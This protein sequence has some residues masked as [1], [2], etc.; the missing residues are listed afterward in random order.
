MTQTVVISPNYATQDDVVYQTLIGLPLDHRK[1]SQG[2]AQVGDTLVYTADGWRPGQPIHTQT[3]PLGA[4]T[5]RVP[6]LA[7]VMAYVAEAIANSGGQPVQFTVLM[8]ESGEVL[9][10]ESG[11]V[12][13]MEQL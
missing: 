12:L 5:T 6:N 8:T 1:L 7:W 13:L 2:D 4:E 10:T 9:M 3:P 11:E